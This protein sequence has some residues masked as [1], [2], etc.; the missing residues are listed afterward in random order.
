MIDALY[1]CAPLPLG[2]GSII[3]P[4]NWGRIKRRFEQNPASIAREAI[5]EDIRRREFGAKP[6]R[7]EAAFACPTLVVAEQYRA[8]HAPTGLIYRVELVDPT[9]QSHTGDHELYLQGF[10]GIDG[11]E[12]LARRYWS[13]ESIGAPELLILSPLKVIECVDCTAPVLSGLKA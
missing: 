13:S 2:P 4:G 1:H 5:L 10:V 8:K 12:S 9:A 11:M 7:L 6:S 3:C